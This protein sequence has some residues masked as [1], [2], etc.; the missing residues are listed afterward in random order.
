M[1]KYHEILQKFWGYT[2]F[3][4]KQLEIIKSIVEENKDTLGLLPTGGGKS[5]IFQVATLAMPEGKQMSIVITPLIALMKDQVENLKKRK[6]PAVA[7]HSGMGRDEI[8]LELNRCVDGYYNFLYISPER[9]NTRNILYRLPNMPIGLITVDE[10]HCISQWGYDFR[11][12]Y[13]KIAEVR[14]II[15]DVPVL[16]LTAS[17]TPKVV[18][19]IQEKLLFKQK[20]VFRL[21]FVRENLVYVVQNSKDKLGDLIRLIKKIPGTGIVYVRSR[22]RTEE[23]ANFLKNYGISADFYHAGISHKLKEKKQEDWK[24]DRT[25]VIVATNAFGMGIDKPDVRFVI[26]MDLPDSLEA[27]YQ[28][29]GRGGRDGKTAYAIILYNYKDIDQLKNSVDL[30]FPPIKTVRKVY[31]AVCN[32]LQIPIGAGMDE[33]YPFNIMEFTTR[34]NMKPLIVLNSLK[35]L[36]K[37]GYLEF[38]DE[39]TESPKVHFI[40]SR[41]DVYRFQVENPPFSPFIKTLLRAYPGI[42]DHF[43]PIN[44][45][46]LAKIFKTDIEHIRKYLK[47]L[48]ELDIIDYKPFIRSNFIYFPQGRLREKDIIFSPETYKFLKDRYIK[49]INSVIQY[50]TNTEKCRSQ[51]LME[52]FGEKDVP[53]CGLCDVCKS[54]SKPNTAEIEEQILELLHQ[55]PLSFDQ[56]FEQLSWDKNKLK[57]ALRSLLKKEKVIFTPDRKFEIK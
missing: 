41:D 51:V 17:A 22:R 30:G 44:E 48:H 53:A 28:E 1:D 25:R 47:K 12:S 56:I 2:S 43:V 8:D 9:L 26:H 14:N 13:L 50:I 23:L 5:V 18:D 52:Y 7:I 21:S 24:Q 46:W 39:I 6:I 3:R 45:F 37:E 31:S 54:K 19:D 38:T 36:Q 11:P 34:Y 27:Y 40:A 10:A 33:S 4:P 20:N 57:Q 29:A 32:F 49:Q 55:S 16:A 35:L 15:P 42:Y